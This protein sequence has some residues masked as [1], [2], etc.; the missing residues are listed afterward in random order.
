VLELSADVGNLHQVI[1]V[2]SVNEPAGPIQR[3]KYNR[4]SCG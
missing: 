3:R 2:I 1:I 4:Q